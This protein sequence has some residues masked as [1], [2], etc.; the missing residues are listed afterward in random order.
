M[1]IKRASVA[2]LLL[3]VLSLGRSIAQGSGK[4]LAQASGQIVRHRFTAGSNGQFLLDRQPFQIRAGSMQYPRVPRAYW[5]DRMRKM[6]SMGLNTLTT[7]VF[8]NVHETSPDNYDFSGENDL[9]E[10]LREAQQEGLYV[11]LRPGPYI[12]AEWEFGGFPAWLLKNHAMQV[13]TRDPLFMAAVRK[14]FNRLGQVVHPLMLS[15]GGPIIA[16]QVENEYGSFGDD[17]V[18]MEEIKEAL[19]A[20]GM[21]DD[22]LYT[23]DG[24][25]YFKGGSLPELPAAVN[26][27]PG[28]AQKSFAALKN[29]RPNGSLMSGEYWD[30]WFDHWGEAHQHRAAGAQESDLKWMLDHGYSFNLYMEEG[31]TTFGWMN[32]ANSNGSNYEPDTT[33]YDYDGPIDEHG[34]L[35]PKFFVFRDLIAKATGVMPPPPPAPVAITA[36]PVRPVTESASLWENL[37]A[38]IHSEFPLSMEDLNQ[39]YGYILYATE[40]KAH[41]AGKL[42]IDGL[43][44]YATIYVDRHLVGS[45]DRRL[46]QSSLQ[47]PSSV[48]SQELEILV[49]NSGRINYTS[50]LQGER[51][52]ITS[53]VTLSAAE[54]RGWNIY[55]LPML[56]PGQMKYK[57]KPCMGPCFFRT[58]LSVSGHAT[59]LLDT[60]VNTTGIRKGTVWIDGR[61]LGRA[62]EIGPQGALY[63]PAGWL[64]EG[65]NDID[66]F[67]LYGDGVSQIGTVTHPI[68]FEPTSPAVTEMENRELWPGSNCTSCT[69]LHATDFPTVARQTKPLGFAP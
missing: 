2:I 30:G 63:L 16:V 33:S 65:G 56:A 58:Q 6:K 5:R 40:L 42:Q 49:E 32:G 13:R 26:F 50:A 27:G 67:D 61:P 25:A 28:D 55:S 23:A 60:Y 29:V 35:R 59:G 37:P 31:G 12:C 68:Y 45:L 14:W 4:P 51:K 24:S 47:L 46:G 34:G 38:P 22:Y 64:H 43:H 7:Y 39:A 66:V 20:S 48:S 11:I 18:Y 52:G 3:T 41:A 21:G 69:P 17:H 15:Q 57:S 62:W 8:W 1:H 53:K 44:D 10:Y 19:K 36:Y 9:G 54:L